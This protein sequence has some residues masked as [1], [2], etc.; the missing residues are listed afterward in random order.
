MASK[1]ARVDGPD[2]AAGRRDAATYAAQFGDL[3]PP[4]AREQ[5]LVEANRC[6][7]C[8]DAPCIEACPTAIDIPGFI[9]KIATDN[10]TGAG[11][12]I[13]EANIFGGACA[14]VCPTEILCERA[15]VRTAQEG[16]PIQIGRLQRYATDPIL[17]ADVHPFPRAAASGKKVAVVGGGPAGLSCAHRLARL[18]HAVT[19]YEARGRLGGLNEYGVAEYKVPEHFARAEVDFVLG[20]GGIEAK[21]GQA[22]GRDISLAQLRRDY[23]AVFLG[24]GLAG[25]KALE[26]EGENV[27]GVANAVD[28]I[29][30][31]RAAEDFARLPVGRRIVVIGG[32]NTAIDIAVQTK[33]LGAE[34]VTLVYRRG[35]ETMGA[36]GHEQ[37]FAAVNGVT[38][39][40]WARPTRLHAVDNRVAAAEFEM[41]RLENGRLVGTGAMF[42][43]RADMVFKAIGQSFVAAPVADGTLDALEL[44]QG[45]IRIDEQFR[46]S[47]AGVWAGGDCVA[48]GQDLTVEAVEHGKRAA[49]SIDAAL[50][51]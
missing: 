13:L 36:T 8:Y 24:M 26:C 45:R 11:M 32:G 49:L 23:D 46:T 34:E 17:A 48:R 44:A 25:V 19:V 15:C 28:Y 2:I 39:R 27:A 41:T 33:R 47:V 22:L 6:Y 9:K 29:A 7:F 18:G 43:L 16:D 42:S 1:E 31:L 12:R 40:H 38:L 50:R 21:T 30:Q 51:G 5:A 37:E 14:R 20:V 10:V 35:P 3:H 4:L